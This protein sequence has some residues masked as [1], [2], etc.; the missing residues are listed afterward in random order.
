MRDR[1]IPLELAFADESLVNW[2]ASGFYG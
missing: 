2:Q 1:T